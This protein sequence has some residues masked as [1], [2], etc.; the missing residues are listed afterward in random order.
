MNRKRLEALQIRFVLFNF[1]RWKLID[2][3]DAPLH[4]GEFR[5]FGLTLY[6]GRQGAGKTISMVDNLNRMR[7]RYPDCIIVTNFGYSGADLFMTSW[8]DFFEIRNGT[9]GVIFCD[10]R[11]S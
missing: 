7:L 9:S 2:I 1:I 8:R 4:S 3:I 6:C 11:D 5:E 10:R